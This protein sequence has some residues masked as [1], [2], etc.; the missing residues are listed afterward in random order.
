[1]RRALSILWYYFTWYR[2]LAWSSGLGLALLAAA[3]VVFFI[4]NPDGPYPWDPYK[5]YPWGLSIYA[6]FFLLC[7]P[8]LFSP[9]AF[10]QLL[11]NRRIALVP[12]IQV[13]AGI[14]L[15]LMTVLLTCLPP[16]SFVLLAP[17]YYVR[18]VRAFSPNTPLMIF[19]IGSAYSLVMQKILPLRNF[20]LIAAVIFRRIFILLSQYGEVVGGVITDPLFLLAAT[21]TCI[22][23]WIGSLVVLSRVYL[24]RPTAAQGSVAAEG[25][26]SATAT[27]MDLGWSSRRFPGG[28]ATPAGTLLLGYPDGTL[29]R[30]KR[31]LDVSVMSPLLCSLFMYLVW[32]RE[33]LAESII[34]RIF[35]AISLMATVSVSM[36]AG[37]LA[38]R[39]RCLW[40]RHGGDRP[41]L[42]HYLEGRLLRNFALY[43]TGTVAICIAMLAFTGLPGP[44][45]LFYLVV[46]TCGSLFCAYLSLGMK[47]NHWPYIAVVISIILTLSV[48]IVSSM[49]VLLGQGYYSGFLISPTVLYG[50]IPGGFLVLALLLRGYARRGFLGID[51]LEVKFRR[52]PGWAT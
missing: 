1:M 46:T 13:S 21:G 43:F 44:L 51:W 2:L 18:M 10:R 17:D 8:Y 50:C 29:I 25:W 24:L 52:T 40:L 34:P 32:N 16:L 49:L 33:Y 9:A 4:I 37:E 11:S 7:V 31:V 26:F 35:L 15:F 45:V 27:S 3:V 12:W 47:I 36:D 41:A 22:L 48:I 6:W 28:V 42:W 5:L 19:I 20:G 23:G 30:I 39:I 14:A 38:A